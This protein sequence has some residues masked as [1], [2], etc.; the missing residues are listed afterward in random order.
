MLLLYSFF[1]LFM[2]LDRHFNQIVAAVLIFFL[3]KNIFLKVQ[4]NV[5]FQGLINDMKA[6]ISHVVENRELLFQKLVRTHSDR[7]YNL[8]MMRCN[9]PSLAED[10]CQ[11][12]FMRAYKGLEKFRGEAQLGTWLYRIALNVCH[13]MIKQESKHSNMLSIDEQDEMELEAEGVNVEADFYNEIQR[14]QIRQA[15]ASLSRVQSDAITL[16]Y[17]KEYQYTEV[18]KIM[19]IPLNTVKSHIRRAKVNLQSILMEV[20]NET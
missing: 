10:I 7:I 18:A 16:Y 17:L 12:T 5:I 3:E 2:V 11:V 13:S 19:D 20:Y 6:S 4:Q 9:Q 14:D 15:I 1:D 8:A